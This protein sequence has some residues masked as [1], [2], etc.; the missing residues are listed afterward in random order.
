[1]LP[2]SAVLVYVFYVYFFSLHRKSERQLVLLYIALFH[3]TVI[4]TTMIFL[5]LF[6]LNWLNYL[7]NPERFHIYK[8]GRS[9]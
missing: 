2:F 3:Y 4:A 8:K 9:C 1:M 5:R 7:F 6:Y